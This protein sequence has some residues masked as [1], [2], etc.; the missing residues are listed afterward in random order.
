MNLNV[1][2]GGTDYSISSGAKMNPDGSEQK[3]KRNHI[4][5][6]GVV[7]VAVLVGIYF[8]KNN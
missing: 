4:L 3:K 2:M 8:I 5:V 1:S 7:V 6:L